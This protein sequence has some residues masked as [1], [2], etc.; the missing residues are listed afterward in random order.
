MHMR[1]VAVAG[2]AICCSCSTLPR[3][4]PPPA[5]SSTPSS[6]GERVTVERVVDGDTFVA[7]G[8]SGRFRVRLIG[9]D[10]PETVKP[11]TPVQCFG[12]ESSAYARARLTGKTV[13]LV[14]DVDRYDRYGRV[15]AYVYV[16][17]SDLFNLDL[18]RD[19]YAVVLTIPPDVAHA[20]EFV[21]AQRAARAH[22]AG[23]WLAC[24]P[25]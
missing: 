5:S 18:V 12:P 11:G 21:A 22:H 10:T 25:H 2:L 23:L 1:I 13:R 24:V 15:L 6:A 9:V 8:S 7:R 19:G 14:F 3:G 16:D 4:A 17:G 20:D